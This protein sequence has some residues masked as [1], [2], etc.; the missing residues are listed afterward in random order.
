MSDAASKRRELR[1]RRIL[2]NAEERK[3]KIFGLTKI[4]SQEKDNGK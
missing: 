4:N 2:E 3:N 1:R